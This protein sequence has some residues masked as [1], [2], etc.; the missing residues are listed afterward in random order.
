MLWPMRANEVLAL[1]PDTLSIYDREEVLLS[2]ARDG[3]IT[4]GG[5]A[6]VPLNDRLEVVV[7]RDLISWGEEGDSVR[8]GLTAFS[9]Q[10][11]ADMLGGVLMTATIA[12]A[13]AVAAME[14][15]GLVGLFPQ[16]INTRTSGYTKHSA[17]IDGA[18]PTNY[19][20]VVA[21]PKDWLISA[22][23]F[24][25]RGFATNYGGY[26]PRGGGRGLT[27]E[28]SMTQPSIGVVQG[29]YEAHHTGQDVDGDLAADSGHADYSQ[30]A[31]VVLALFDRGVFVDIREGITGKLGPEI[32][33]MLNHEGVSLP[34]SRLP[35]V[36]C[37][38][39]MDRSVHDGRTTIARDLKPENPIPRITRPGESGNAVIAWQMALM[40]DGYELPRFGVDGD[41]GDETEAATVLWLADRGLERGASPIATPS[42]PTPYNVTFGRGKSPTPITD[43]APESLVP[44]ENLIPWPLKLVKA[45]SYGKGR[46]RGELCGITIH[47]AE[48]AERG[49]GAEALANYA[50]NNRRVVSWHFAVDNNSVSYSVP[51]GDRAYAAGPGNDRHIHIE[52][53]ARAG[54]SAAQWADAFSLATLENLAALVAWLCVENEIVVRRLDAA[55]LLTDSAGICGHV[56]WSSAS[57]T[58]RRNGLKV[59]PWWNP[60]KGAWRSTNH[61][62]PGKHFP[63]A[64]FMARVR[65]HVALRLSLAS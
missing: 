41:H 4:F 21:G 8:L 52:V 59:D 5:W 32:A 35:G 46:T 16:Q 38:S 7:T 34:S 63:W 27:L 37:L 18:L 12:D 47:T 42:R 29:P 44:V 20:G 22:D 62:D 55:Q 3:H 36:P 24:A 31:R 50:Q 17:A 61:G 13:V 2:M 49:N 65:Q 43:P 23:V 48:M 40:V 57:L 25:K 14:Q 15:G 53:V 28:N 19:Q 9:Q 33:A 60:A 1:I 30:L 45:T 11:L 58:A 51:V 56:D 6:R 64:A 10:Q 39:I 54:Q 26:F